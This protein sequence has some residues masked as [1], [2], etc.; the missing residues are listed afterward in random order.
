[1]SKCKRGL[2]PLKPHPK[3]T[4][5]I[6]CFHPIGPFLTRDLH[7]PARLSARRQSLSPGSVSLPLGS[8]LAPLSICST[9]RQRHHQKT[10]T[11]LSPSPLIAFRSVPFL[12]FPLPL[13]LPLLF[14]QQWRPQLQL[15]PAPRRSHRPP[16][17]L[18]P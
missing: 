10:P 11:S 4:I 3:G 13:L 16:A 9:V 14:L 15:P 5:Q 7:T 2:K 12:P 17:S 18:A 8:A 1:M 6:F